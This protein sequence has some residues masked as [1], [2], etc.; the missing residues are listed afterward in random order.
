MLN[1]GTVPETSNTTPLKM[2]SWVHDGFQIWETKFSGAMFVS[3]MEGMIFWLGPPGLCTYVGSW[4]LACRFFLRPSSS[5]VFSGRVFASN[6]CVFFR[7]A[8][9]LYRLI[10]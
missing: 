9:D 4:K 2:E 10:P 1:F 8:G 3:F 5:R 7:L 6:M